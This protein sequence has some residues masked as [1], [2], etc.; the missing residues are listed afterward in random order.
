[1]FD[2]LDDPQPYVPRDGLRPEVGR[3]ARSLRRRRRAAVGSAAAVLLVVAGIAGATTVVDRKLDQVD[4][5][6]VPSL[7]TT[8]E[9]GDPQV[10]LFVGA[11]SDEGMEAPSPERSG[12]ARGDTILLARV[13][14]G[15]EALTMLSIP[16]DLLVDIPGHGLERI[17]AA[18]AYGGPELLVETIDQNLGI[19]VDRYLETGFHGAAALGDALGGISLDFP[20]PVRDAQTGLDL[21][22]G[23][24]KLDGGQI[25]AVGRARH[26]RYLEDGAWKADGTSDLGRMLRQQVIAEALLQRLTDV[27]LADP[28]ELNRLLDVAAEDLT[29]DSATS[30]DELIALFRAIEGARPTG[31]Q[32]PVADL[33]HEGAVV[34]ELGPGADQV[35]AAFLGVDRPQPPS[36]PQQEG[37]TTSTRDATQPPADPAAPTIPWPTPEQAIPAP[38]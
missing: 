6:D 1:M 14:P 7:R 32:Y 8:T 33:V 13:D 25:L 37:S 26:V 5:V 16:R 21:P 17:N 2:H 20:R 29:I 22:A 11:D 24:T 10:V 28:V 3:R 15:K 18:L 30:H 19:E 35:T 31:L 36:A 23:C 9:P 12:P 38:C 27:D 34:L 4:T